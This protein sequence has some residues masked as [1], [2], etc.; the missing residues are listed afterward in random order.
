ML[1]PLASLADKFLAGGQCVFEVPSSA[2]IPDLV[3][4]NVDGSVAEERNQTGP[5]A[6]PVALRLLMTASKA[7][8]PLDRKWSGDFLAEM[9]GVSWP[10]L[11]KSVLPKLI[12]GGHLEPFQNG[13]LLSRRFK[14]VAK[15]LVTVEAKLRDWRGAVTQAARHASSADRAWVAMD[16]RAFVPNDALQ[17]WF[18]PYGVG[19]A[20]LSSSG[21][22]SK[23]QPPV[24]RRSRPFDRELLAERTWAVLASGRRSGTIPTVFGRRLLA[25]GSDPRLEGVGAR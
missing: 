8:D 7:A 20:T 4:I 25:T 16:A 11:K 22:L 24:A 1:E 18:K 15:R 23:L 9:A 17:S 21:A 5:L 12:E 13:W 6:D 14:S 2:G 10:H 3:L 19:L